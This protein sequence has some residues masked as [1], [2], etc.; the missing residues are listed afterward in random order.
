MC[1]ACS[2]QVAVVDDD[3]NTLRAISRLL[4]VSGFET[5]SFASAEE[6]LSSG[7]AG[8]TTCVVVDIYLNGMSGIDLRLRLSVL[9]PSLP[10]I[11]MTGADD[12]T[13]RQEALAAG[14]VAFLR[15]PVE[16]RM[17]I[18]AIRQAR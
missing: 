6:F 11:F 12:E 15:K 7:A 5:S 13:T 9:N 8:R 10:V 2:G 17:L 16:G 4:K 18:D 3:V 1:M 14:C